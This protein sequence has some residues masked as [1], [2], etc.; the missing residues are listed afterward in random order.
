MSDFKDALSLT[1]KKLFTEKDHYR[2]K[3]AGV[4]GHGPTLI[5]LGRNAE[6]LF[7]GV[8]YLDDRVK[9]YIKMLAKKKNDRITSTMYI[10]IALFFKEEH[11]EIYSKTVT[12]LQ[13]FDYIA[14]LL[15]G[16][17][18]AASSSVG[19]KPWDTNSLSKAGLDPAK[20]PQIHYMGEHIGN[21]TESAAAAYGLPANIPVFAVGVDF[22]AALVGANTL[23]KGKSCERSGSS[24]GINLCW[25]KYID[26]SRL[27][28][29]THFIP[30]LWNVAG[31]TS[32]S[33]IALEWIKNIVGSLDFQSGLKEERKD[34]IIF[35]PYLIGERTPLWD[36]YAKGTFFGLTAFHT[37]EDMIFAVYL[38]IVFSIRDCIEIIEHNKCSFL[39]PIISTGWGA[40]YDWFIQLK[41]DVTGKNFAKIQSKDAELLGISIVCASSLG[42]HESI[43]KAAEKIVKVKK[44]FEPDSN[45]FA[46]FTESFTLYKNL[47]RKLMDLF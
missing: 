22:A 41:A 31:I 20:F 40:Q 35:L 11:P 3:A 18:S 47:Q 21:I 30:D 34:A 7:T 38:G 2:I 29:Y 39:F 36:P 9:K 27:L 8:G 42:R 26:D 15:T 37:K 14:F 12:F 28:S 24:G 4:T 17:I 25:D 32:T 43:E 6:P 33:G 10:P 13:A 44:L 45:R 46:H 16:E 5:P 23:Q 1:L 19:I